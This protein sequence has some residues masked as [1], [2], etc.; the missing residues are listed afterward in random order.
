MSDQEQSALA[1]AIYSD[2]R[3]FVIS[4]WS[5]MVAYARRSTARKFATL[6]ELIE[7]LEA[8]Q[9]P[10]DTVVRFEGRPVSFGPTI[11]QPYMAPVVGTHTGQRLGPPIVSHNAALALLGQTLTHWAPVGFFPPPADELVQGYVYPTDAQACGTLSMLPFG[12]RIPYLPLLAHK[13]HLHRFDR[14]S[15]IT[16]TVRMLGPHDFQELKIDSAK[17]EVLRKSGNVWFLD[18]SGDESQA[19]AGKQEDDGAQLWGALYA[20]GHFEFEKSPNREHLIEAFVNAFSHCGWKVGLIREAK[21]G[22]TILAGTG[23]RM[24]VGGGNRGPVYS[25][26]MDAEMLT[27][28][29]EAHV[30]F[31]S[32]IKKLLLAAQ[33]V[34]DANGT[35]LLNPRDL[36]FCYVKEAKSFTVMRSNHADRL[37]HPV[38]VSIRDWHRR[39][40][41][42][43]KP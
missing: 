42:S 24:A 34:F 8:G 20:C 33:E 27:G 36:D 38:A 7:A 13:R 2:L 5:R 29:G 30:K 10:P 22:D 35:E 4:N 31:Q 3:D 16:G 21:S 39:K 28:Y 9:V 32:L 25:L 11:R 15:A 17:Y 41:K 43:D 14:A 19:L 40:N 26:H 18:L 23:V 37:S 1:L 6:P 12:P